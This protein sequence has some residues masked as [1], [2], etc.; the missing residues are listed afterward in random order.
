M[1][2]RD[3]LK[4]AGSAATG[5]L[6]APAGAIELDYLIRQDTILDVLIIGAGLAG[7]R[8]AQI[9]QEQGL[10]VHVLEAR[11]RVGGRTLNQSFAMGALAEGGG[12]WVSSTQTHIVNLA[13]SL[14]IDIFP[15][16][17]TGES[18]SLFGGQRLRDSERATNPAERLDKEQ[19]VSALDALARNVPLYTPWLAPDAKA[20]DAQTLGQWLD[21]HTTTEGARLELEYEVSAT[22]SAPSAR[23]S[24]LWFLFYVHSA[25]GYTRLQSIQGG[26][27]ELRVVG[28]AQR[29]SEQL[30]VL[31]DGHISLSKPVLRVNDMSDHVEVH[32]G[33][34]ILRASRLVVA[35]MP[36][37]AQGISF[38]PPLPTQHIQLQKDWNGAS[39]MKA[40]IA[41]PNAFWRGDGLN[42]Q[43]LTDTPVGLVFDNSQPGA[44]PGVLVAFLEAA[45]LPTDA[46]LRRQSV[47]AV[48]QTLFGPQ[49]SQPVGYIE[50]DWQTD[51]YS[52]GCVSPLAPGVITGPGPALGQPH[53]YI[54]WAGAETSP[55]WNGYMEGAVRSGE[56]VALEVMDALLCQA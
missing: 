36:S 45:A 6:G 49:A 48:L 10:S 21:A 55:V 12:Q 27:Q 47:L 29:I 38:D 19:A 2:R 9:L 34:D 37:A 35:M 24:L 32:L 1:K 28:G 46:V 23:I 51:P 22:L 44:E 54:H 33:N 25:G 17:N 39:G 13:R 53:G 56:R 15:T 8:A 20:L 14:G 42:G 3:F 18:L 11:D 40:H 41:Y 30:A 7:L 26:A 31:L 4:L 16:Y 43:A 52:T 50:Y 5:A